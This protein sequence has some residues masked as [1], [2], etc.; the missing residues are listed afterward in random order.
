MNFIKT[1]VLRSILTY[2]NLD[3]LVRELGNFLSGTVHNPGSDEARNLVAGVKALRELC[4]QFLTN[5]G[6]Q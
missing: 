1:W 4:N 6:E 5:L 3:F 2:G